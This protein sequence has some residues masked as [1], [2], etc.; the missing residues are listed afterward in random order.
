MVYIRTGLV[1][2]MMQRDR[3]I[4]YHRVDC[5]C[6]NHYPDILLLLKKLLATSL[7][8]SLTVILI[9]LWLT[10]SRLK[11]MSFCFE[12]GYMHTSEL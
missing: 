4:G 12:S 10:H 5:L 3:L 1:H 9:R 11:F 8:L 2:T 6:L 7:I